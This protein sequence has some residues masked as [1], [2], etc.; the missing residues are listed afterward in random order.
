MS[1]AQEMLGYEEVHAITSDSRSGLEAAADSDCGAITLEGWRTDAAMDAAL[2]VDAPSSTD[3][4]KALSSPLGAVG[5]EGLYYLPAQNT[6]TLESAYYK[7]LPLSALPPDGTVGPS[8]LDDYFPGGSPWG[9]SAREAG[10]SESQCQAG[11]WC[12]RPPRACQR[13]T[14]ASQWMRGCASSQP[15][16]TCPETPAGTPPTAGSSFPALPAQRC[17][18]RRSRGR[19]VRAPTCPAL[20]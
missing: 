15:L 14:R 11:R 8:Q 20:R 6:T 13:N 12:A 2:L 16:T 3:G 10:W 5:S 18:S 4:G 9:C 19:M 17:T 7:T 1:P